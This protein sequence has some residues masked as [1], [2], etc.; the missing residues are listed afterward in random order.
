MCVWLVVLF[1]FLR[2]GCL[3]SGQSERAEYR[4]FQKSILTVI[5]LMYVQAVVCFVVGGWSGWVDRGSL[6][7]SKFRSAAVL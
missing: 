5:S 3:A 7:H 4:Y 2:F 1:L 6:T